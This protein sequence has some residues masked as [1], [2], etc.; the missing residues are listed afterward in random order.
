[1]T[2]EAEPGQGDQ[3]VDVVKAEGPAGNESD[4]RFHGLDKR[5]GQPVLECC[6]DLCS[7]S[8]DAFREADERRDPAA[9]GPTDPAI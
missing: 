1:V 2:A 3:G 8:T 4:L 9:L 7:P 5:V 6:D